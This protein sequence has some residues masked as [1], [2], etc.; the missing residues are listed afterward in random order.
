MRNF[1][2]ALIL[3]ACGDNIHPPTP[4]KNPPDY[5]TDDDLDIGPWDGPDAGVDSPP[6]APDAQECTDSHIDLNGQEHKCQHDQ[7]LP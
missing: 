4:D 1:L 7:D 5:S 3:A 6:A 2:F